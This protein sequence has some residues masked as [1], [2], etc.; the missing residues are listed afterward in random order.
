[1]E[2]M[3]TPERS[4]KWMARIITAVLL[5]AEIVFAAEP[6]HIQTAHA[7]FRELH[8]AS[9]LKSLLLKYDLRKYTFTHQI[10]IERGVMNHAFPVLTINLH[11]LD[12]PN[13]LLG[14]YIHEQLHWYLRIHNTQRVEAIRRLGQIFP[15]APTA[16]PIGAGTAVSTYGHLVVG[17]L[18]VQALRQLIGPKKTKSVIRQIPWYTWIWKTV[19]TDESTIGTVVKAEHLEIQ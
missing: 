1:M 17:Y 5:S 8:E 16:Y 10:L 9:E 12:S 3:F 18:E 7:T 2:T 13:G 14:T 4:A 6:I 11:D 15:D 19:L